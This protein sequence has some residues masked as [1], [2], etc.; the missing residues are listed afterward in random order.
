MSHCEKFRCAQVRAGGKRLGTRRAFELL[1]HVVNG[2][3]MQQQDVLA[4][5]GFRAGLAEKIFAIAVDRLVVRGQGG[6]PAEDLVANLTPEVFAA[7]V[8]GLDLTP[9]CAAP[10]EAP[11]ADLAGEAFLGLDLQTFVD[12]PDVRA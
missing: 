12:G 1:V 4:A 5:E 7:F 9:E 6:V 11:L 3:D 8:D 10:T 2:P